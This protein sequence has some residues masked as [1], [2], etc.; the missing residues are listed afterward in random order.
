MNTHENNGPVENF[1]ELP[2]GQ[3][4]YLDWGGAGP[5]THLLHANGF[6]AGTYSPFVEHL[7]DE[8]HVVAS[9][10]RGHGRSELPNSQ[11]IRDWNVFVDDLKTLIEKALTPPIIGMGHSLGA[12]TTYIA[13][14][15]NPHLFSCLVLLDPTIL[16][17]RYLWAMAFLRLFGLIGNIPLAKSARRRRKTFQGKKEALK[18]FTAGR[19][20]FKYWSKDFVEAYLECGLLEKDAETAILKC[21]PE[22]EAQIFESVPFDV[23]KYA[24]KISCPVLAIR[25]EHS[26]AFTVDAARRLERTIPDCKV[27]TIPTAGHFVPMGKPAECARVIK[28]FISR[29]HG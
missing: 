8:L 9:D 1:V 21:D 22:L 5:L 6:C 24:K 20:A 13:A 27:I 29:R 15:R 4:H 19:G 23:W 17:R 11:R 25:G 12:V 16:P 28:E 10:I 26:G 2:D 3:T 7:A 14:A 18:R